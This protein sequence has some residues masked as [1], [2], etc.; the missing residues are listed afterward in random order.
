MNEIKKGTIIVSRHIN[1]DTVHAYQV[2]VERLNEDYFR[3]IN[4]HSNM[5]MSG[6][7]TLD[8]NEVTNYIEGLGYGHEI[9]EIINE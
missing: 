1:T 3:L 4:L 8:I 5:I 6:F 2:L 9:L 7:K